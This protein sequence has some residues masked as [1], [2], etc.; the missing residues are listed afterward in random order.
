MDAP[1]IKGMTGTL[2]ATGTVGAFHSPS[3][4]PTVH[5]QRL[6][7]LY[8]KYASTKDEEYR[9]ITIANA[10][11]DTYGT[12]LASAIIQHNLNRQQL[13][14]L[15]DEDTKTLSRIYPELA[16]R[17]RKI[18]PVFYKAVKP[19]SRR[20]VRWLEEEYSPRMLELLSFDNK[21][22]ADEVLERLD[23]IANN[24]VNFTKDEIVTYNQSVDYFKAKYT[25]YRTDTASLSDLIAYKMFLIDKIVFKAAL[26]NNKF[27]NKEYYFTK[28]SG[29]ES[30]YGVWMDSVSPE[31]LVVPNR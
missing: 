18:G 13:Y 1:Q 14:T 19:N 3:E 12:F 4:V 29:I 10:L 31:P 2:S 26:K 5:N 24:E 8:R 25:T 9:I 7:D 22:T 30:Y 23:H 15:L 16:E 20:V 21:P 17:V 6:D 27:F 11:Y 28:Y